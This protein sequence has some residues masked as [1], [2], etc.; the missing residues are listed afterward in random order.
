[1]NKDK[2]AHAH[3]TQPLKAKES[4]P[5]VTAQ[6]NREDMVLGEISQADREIQ[7]NLT[8]VESKH[9]DLAEAEG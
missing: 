9:D 7:R 5:W 3:W 8:S 6:M 4:L 1:M 2:V